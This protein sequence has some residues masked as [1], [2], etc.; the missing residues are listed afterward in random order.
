MK[1]NL[2]IAFAILT[3]VANLRGQVVFSGAFDQGS[4]GKVEL[5]DSTSIIVS[6]GDTMQCLSY[7]L[8]GRFDPENPVDVSLPANANWYAFSMTGVKGKQIYLTMRDNG[9][10][11]TSYSYD[12]KNWGHMKEYESQWHKIG[13]RFERDTVYIALY[14]PYTYP[15]HLS[16]MAEWSSRKDV[17][18]DTIGFSF[19]GRPLQLLHITDSSVPAGGKKRVWIHGRI[20]PSEAPGSWLLDGLVEELTSDSP[21]A[22]EIR[23]QI[24]FYILPFTNPDGVANGLSRSNAT[25]VNQEINYG[26]SVDSTVVEVRAIKQALSRLIAQGPLDLLINNHSQLADFATFWMHRSEGTTE[27]Y[28]NMQWTLTGLTSSFNPY[29]RPRD[30]CFSS[31][32]PR[33]VEGWVWNQYKDAGIAITLETPYNCFSN[34][35]QGEW[36]NPANMH[37]FGRRL[38]EAIAEY[39]EISTPGRIIVETPDKVSKDWTTL[40]ESMSYMGKNGL[41]ALKEGAKIK[42]SLDNL[43]SGQ[44]TIYRYVA[45]KNIHPAKGSEFR[46]SDEDPG[47]HGWVFESDW[48]QKKDG[49]FRYTY[50]AS[51]AGETADALL[52]VK[53]R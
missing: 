32:A 27:R 34:N 12:G 31:I 52:I 28:Q 17:Q 4:L 6:P 24:D 38:L 10:H 49:K 41:K 18:L 45:G 51:Q 48:T 21:A 35:T 47:V 50:S 22:K 46:Q 11:G 43:E 37:K 2:L 36:S 25:G 3:S 1:K 42:Y 9:V 40:D 19:E 26:R 39:F 23:K 30:M 53:L 14:E 20:H 44:Y 8:S 7:V 15:Y 5:L 29:L 13:K 33:Y 16:R